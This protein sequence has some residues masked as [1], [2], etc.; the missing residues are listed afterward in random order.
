M[1]A[2]APLGAKTGRLRLAARSGL[3]SALSLATVAS[4]RALSAAV[5]PPRRSIDDDRGRELAAREAL[6]GVQRLD[7]LGVAGQ[8]RRRLVLLRV[9]ELARLASPRRRRR[10]RARSANTTHLA[11]RPAGSA[12]SRSRHRGCGASADLSCAAPAS[13]SGVV[14][15]SLAGEALADVRGGARRRPASRPS[16]SGT[17][18][19]APPGEHDVREERAAHDARQRRDVVARQRDLA[20]RRE[21]GSRSPAAGAPNASGCSG[22]TVCSSRISD[23]AASS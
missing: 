12:R 5:S 9:L 22:A 2:A 19:P 11:R 1:I 15:G 21:R 23:S 6:D 3:R 14:T 7:R 17:P 4:M 16:S 20:H 10:A 18:S 13:S 8:E